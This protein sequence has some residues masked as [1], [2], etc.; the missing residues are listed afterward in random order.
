MSLIKVRGGSKGG[1]TLNYDAFSIKKSGLYFNSFFI[2]S[3]NFQEKK[4][5]EIFFDSENPY[6]IYFEFFDENTDDGFGLIRTGR[7][8]VSN[9]RTTKAKTAFSKSNVL[10]SLIDSPKNFEIKFSTHQNKFYAQLRPNFE[11]RIPFTEKNKID[12]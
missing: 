2:K 4:S 1:R 12:S 3:K 7:D 11:L 8:S 6:I 10:R 5:V 9:G